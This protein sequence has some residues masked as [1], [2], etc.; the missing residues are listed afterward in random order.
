MPGA[1]SAAGAAPDWVRELRERADRPPLQPRVALA[2]GEARC[3]IGSIEPGLALRLAQAGLPLADAGEIRIIE[4]AAA[5]DAS[6]AAIAHWLAEQ[7]LAGRWRHEKL[8]VLDDQGR[9]V[10]AI[11]RAAVRPLGIVTQAVHL[12]GRDAAGGWWLQQRAL[13]KDTDPG[14]WDTLVGGLVAHGESIART[15]ARETWEEAGLRIDALQAVVPLGVVTVRR[16]LAEGYMVEHMH[17]FEAVLP[18]GL[19]P[20]NQ[21]GEVHRFERVDDEVLVRRLRNGEFTLEAAL[22]MLRAAGL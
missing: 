14:R 21:D 6:L 10:A 16:P 4:G 1:G 9:S 22:A 8:S 20:L 12:V 19:E 15:L 2:L 17:L 13:D 18:E 3:R 11:E 5:A 7:G